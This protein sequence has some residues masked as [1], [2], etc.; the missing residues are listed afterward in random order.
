MTSTMMQ[1][2]KTKCLEDRIGFRAEW[3][4]Y[5]LYSCRRSQFNTYEWYWR[6]WIHFDWQASCPSGSGDYFRI[7]IWTSYSI[8]TSSSSSS[9]R[10]IQLKQVLTTAPRP[11]CCPEYV[12]HGWKKTFLQWATE[13]KMTVLEFLVLLWKEA[14]K[15]LWGPFK[16]SS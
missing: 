16:S 15:C 2:P 14:A 8:S 6:S 7:I 13:R 5:I 4:L 11:N 3:F 12:K 10:M 9:F 1:K